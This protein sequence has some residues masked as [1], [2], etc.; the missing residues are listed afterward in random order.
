MLKKGSVP[1]GFF[2]ADRFGT[3]ADCLR[4]LR[5]EPAT[6]GGGGGMGGCY[7]SRNQIII[8]IFQ[9]CYFPIYNKKSHKDTNNILQDL[10]AHKFTSS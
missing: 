1:T 8:G 4:Q 9:L 10:Q 7:M 2:S 5:A 3:P 6:V